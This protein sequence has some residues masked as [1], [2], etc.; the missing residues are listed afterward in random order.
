MHLLNKNKN[1]HLIIEISESV[2]QQA[3]ILEVPNFCKI[4]VT[5]D[6]S[7]GV[8]EEYYHSYRMMFLSSLH[9]SIKIGQNEINWSTYEKNCLQSDKR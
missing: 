4:I 5:T 7:H 8:L 9:F 2:L 1:I 6:A 3:P